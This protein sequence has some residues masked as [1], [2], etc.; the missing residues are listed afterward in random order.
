M[1]FAN[2]AR[3]AACCCGEAGGLGEDGKRLPS[4]SHFLS[5]CCLHGVTPGEEASAGHPCGGE[6][7]SDLLSSIW[8]R[9]HEDSHCHRQ[10]LSGITRRSPG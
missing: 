10:L 6:C 7:D 3:G 2:V 8:T 5:R 1:G 9:E 4:H